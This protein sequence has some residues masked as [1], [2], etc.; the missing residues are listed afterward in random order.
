MNLAVENPLYLLLLPVF[1]AG[2]IFSVKWLKIKEKGRKAGIVGLRMAVAACLILALAGVSINWFH[3][4]VT[5]VFVLDV[6]DSAKDQQA[7]GEKFITEALKEMSSKDEVGIIAFGGDARIEQFVTD[8]PLFSGIETTPAAAA[9]NLEGAVQTAMGLYREDSIK[10]MVLITDGVENEGSLRKMAGNLIGNEVEVKVLK[11][12]PF[13]QDEVYVDN[14]VIPDKV[15]IGD[16]FQVE[17]L[18]KSN[19]Q[20]QAVLSLYSGSAKK[21]E[22]QVELEPGE[23]RF[24]FRDVQKNPGIAG[25]RV[26]IDPIKDTRSINNEY[27]AYTR[28]ETGERILLIEGAPG[29]ADAFAELLKAA[30]ISF[31]RI[32]PK[33]APAAMPELNQYKVVITLDVHRDDL[34][35]GFLEILESYVGDYGGGFAAIGGQNS[36]ALGNYKDTVLEEVLP[37]YMDL[38]GKKEIPETALAMVID[39]SGSMS[40][41]ESHTTLLELAKRAAAESIKNLRPIDSVG[42]LAFESTFEWVVPITQV[43]EEGEESLKDK[44]YSI[45]LGGGTSIFPAVNEA[46]QRLLERDAKIRHIILLT[47]GQDGYNHYDELLKQLRDNEVTLS[48]VAVGEGADTRLLK[49]LA[50]EGGGRYYYAD[51]KTDIPRIFSQEVMLSAKAYLVNREFTPEVNGASSVIGD[52]AQYGLPKLYGYVASTKKELAVSHFAS[53][54]GDP[55]LTT[56][57]YG[58]GKTAAFNSDGENTW[59]RDYAGW[60]KYP[61]LWKN[62]INYL[63]TDTEQG[64]NSIS[65]EQKGSVAQVAFQSEN[66]TASTK[67]TAFYHGDNGEKGEIT[68]E[69]EAPGLFRGEMKLNESGLYS[70][71]IRQE[72]DGKVVNSQ[73]TALATQYS[74]EYRFS[75]EA[76]VLEDFVEETKGSFLNSGDWVFEKTGQRAKA[77]ASLDH[78]LLLMAFLLFLLDICNR[79]FRW[80]PFGWIRG[81]LPKGRDKP[82]LDKEEK[83]P[84]LEKNKNREKKK[85]KKERRQ[86]AET[87]DTAELLSKK[88]NR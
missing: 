6:S 46:F 86:P 35:S 17:V 85:R 30:G 63:T 71:N 13:R 72:E 29:K 26:R 83:M 53:D 10:R 74:N 43:Q 52:L 21:T 84:A 50:E 68:L 65:L 33:G 18:V 5:T 80:K 88:K 67:V 9:T 47:D 2:I 22:E 42:V 41:S 14:I 12:S 31:D 58:L 59:T 44:I 54:T 49:Q 38:K 23:N 61:Q 24:L 40:D 37:V 56:W 76:S 51:R 7:Y 77:S 57:Q 79:R 39:R 45:G 15:S 1:W 34:E 27:V 75:D 62:L 8:K 4:S 36:F 25:Y 87:L 32:T 3:S 28:A 70:I 20:T 48:A 78:G 73:N 55:I 66:Y 19:V 69:A 16:S 11:L 82:P 60:D 81:R 64:D